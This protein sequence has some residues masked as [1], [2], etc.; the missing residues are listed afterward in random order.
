MLAAIAAAEILNTA[1]GT[2]ASSFSA[3]FTPAVAWCM[4]NEMPD[5]EPNPIVFAL[6]NLCGLDELFLNCGWQPPIDHV[7]RLRGGICCH[8]ETSIVGS[9]ACG[10]HARSPRPP[11]LY[12]SLG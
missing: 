6:I 11:S 3:S 8:H 10:E 4:M 1:L 9:Q 5:E 2:T 7:S 12:Q